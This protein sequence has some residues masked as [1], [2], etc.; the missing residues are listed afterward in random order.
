MG[1]HWESTYEL[2]DEPELSEISRGNVFKGRRFFLLL[3]LVEA[4]A[5]YAFPG[6]S[7][8]DV[9]QANKGTG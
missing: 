1:H 7:G 5:V 9:F 8:D 3:A 4:D 6:S 2:R